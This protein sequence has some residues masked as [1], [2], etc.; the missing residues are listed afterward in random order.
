MACEK[1]I[2]LMV[3]VLAAF[4]AVV[5]HHA[6]DVSDWLIHP[7]L[8]RVGM[9]RQKAKT[10]FLKNAHK[11]AHSCRAAAR[12]GGVNGVIVATAATRQRNVA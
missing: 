3:A 1:A 4:A 2:A 6:A 8:F 9:A 11:R 7:S 12:H 5:M 10:G